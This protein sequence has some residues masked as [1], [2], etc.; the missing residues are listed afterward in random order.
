MIEASTELH[1]NGKGE[2]RRI[3]HF[4]K[5]YWKRSALALTGL[6]I[7]VACDLAVPRL[8]EKIIDQGIEA[9]NMGVVR[10]TSII[11]LIISV[12][13]AIAAVL[14]SNSSVRVGESVARDLRETLFVKIAGFSYG[15]LDEFP[16]GP[17]M[18]RLTSDAS[19][20]QRFVQVSL[21]I[22]TRGLSP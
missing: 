6:V 13:N 7:M 2:V 3:L 17:L 16:T 10:N 11:M 21:R 22:G 9:K 14:N 8:V 18:V 20:V 1:A 4:A 19:A 12:M 5:P 15:N